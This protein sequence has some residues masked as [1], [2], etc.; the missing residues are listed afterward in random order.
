MAT[1]ILTTFCYNF[2]SWGRKFFELWF[3]LYYQKQKEHN[4]PVTLMV[5]NIAKNQCVC[6][7]R[8]LPTLVQNL[9]A[10][11]WVNPSMAHHSIVDLFITLWCRLALND[12]HSSLFQFYSKGLY[13]QNFWQT[14]TT[15]M[16]P[17]VP[18]Y[19]SDAHFCVNILQFMHKDL[20]MGVRGF[21]ITG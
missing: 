3:L 14:L 13:S 9:R 15:S 10:R 11:L 18:Y 4:A 16:W 19:E 21:V 6:R 12:R 1:F 7:T 8:T 2:A 17:G 20:R 5:S